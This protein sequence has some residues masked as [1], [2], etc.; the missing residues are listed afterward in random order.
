MNRVRLVTHT[1]IS[2]S[3]AVKT[4]LRMKGIDVPGPLLDVAMR[5]AQVNDR[6]VEIGVLKDE[7][8]GTLSIILS[9]SSLM[10]ATKIVRRGGIGISREG[11]WYIDT[12]YTEHQGGPNRSGEKLLVTIV[13]LWIE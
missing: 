13:I 10:K 7:S 3:G 6:G 2:F 12:G 1:S 11:T 5:A 8:E 9:R 4:V